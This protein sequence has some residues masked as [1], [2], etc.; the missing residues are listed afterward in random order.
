MAKELNVVQ[1]SCLQGSCAGLDLI[2][3]DLETPL[4]F[5]TL[6][7]SVSLF[8]EC[9]KSLKSLEFSSRAI[10]MSDGS[11]LKVDG[12][13]WMLLV[14]GTDYFCSTICLSIDFGSRTLNSWRKFGLEL[15]WKRMN[16]VFARIRMSNNPTKITSA[17]SDLANEWTRLIFDVRH[18]SDGNGI[19][20]RQY[21]NIINVVYRLPVVRYDWLAC[22]TWLRNMRN[23]HKHG[24]Q[25]ITIGD[26]FF[27]F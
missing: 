7:R 16:P 5:K 11:G 3:A 19:F 12:N 17:T 4:N 18:L 2:E 23:A 20:S 14:E 1:H 9:K 15:C 24:C 13:C 10:Q 8:F 26:R 22:D 21:S 27:S 6:K 25:L